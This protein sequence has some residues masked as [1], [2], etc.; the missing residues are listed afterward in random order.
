MNRRILKSKENATSSLFPQT[1][2]SIFI[3]GFFPVS[4]KEMERF[5]G[6]NVHDV[7]SDRGLDRGTALLRTLITILFPQCK[8]ENAPDKRCHQLGNDNGTPYAVHS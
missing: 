4:Q 3:S 1:P 2:I 7:F 6:K 8:Y 5:I